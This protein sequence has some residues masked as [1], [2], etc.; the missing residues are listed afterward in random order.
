MTVVVHLLVDAVAVGVVW[1]LVRREIGR[2]FGRMLVHGC[3][4]FGDVPAKMSEFDRRIAAA[5]QQASAAAQTAIEASAAAQA[6]G[7]R[8]ARE[9]RVRSAPARGLV[10]MGGH[11]I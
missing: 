10:G 8:K 1:W 4:M 7:E 6:T 9:E 2:Q 11:R 3:P 5:E